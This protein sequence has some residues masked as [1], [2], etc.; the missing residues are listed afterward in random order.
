MGQ[1]HE[2]I[3]YYIL[4]VNIHN[5]Y[6]IHTCAITTRLLHIL[7]IFYIMYIICSVVKTGIY[8][9]NIIFKTVYRMAKWR[10]NNFLYNTPAVHAYY[11]CNNLQ[12]SKDN[13]WTS[14]YWTHE[15]KTGITI[16]VKYNL[17]YL[18]L[19]T[20]LQ[21]HSYINIIRT[22]FMYY[23]IFGEFFLFII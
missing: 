15:C 22:I 7:F 3:L 11:M 16:C 20:S 23:Y 2:S 14:L 9:Y 18:R 19:Y 17:S 8:K 21:L 12:C 13:A 10:E 6:H 4:C 5:T 1:V